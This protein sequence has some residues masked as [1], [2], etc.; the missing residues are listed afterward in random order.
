MTADRCAV[1]RTSIDLDWDAD[2]CPGGHVAVCTRCD[3]RGVCDEC[4]VAA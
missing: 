3:W 1:C 2:T 4:E